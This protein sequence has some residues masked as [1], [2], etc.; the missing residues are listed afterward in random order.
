MITYHINRTDAY[1]PLLFYS[2]A[3]VWVTAIEHL[4]WVSRD[5]LLDDDEYALVNELT[6]IRISRDTQNLIVQ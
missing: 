3:M 6:P 2:A 4:F 1:Q 5:I